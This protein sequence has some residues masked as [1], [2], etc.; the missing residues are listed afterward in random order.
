VIRP[1]A[2]L[3]NGDLEEAHPDTA[4]ARYRAAYPELFVAGAPA[5]DR[6]NLNAAIDL[7]ATYLRQGATGRAN[8]LLDSAAANFA[9]MP[10]L[11]DFGYRISDVHVHA[12]RGEKAKALAALRDAQA[13]GWH[14][15]LWRYH[16]DF[17]PNLASIRS[18]PEFK[19]I[20]GDIERDMAQQRARLA[21]SGRQE[22]C[23]AERQVRTTRTTLRFAQPTATAAAC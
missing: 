16:R 19:A 15:P 17:D 20:F 11:G 18:A 7:A 8:L 22:E 21:A 2:I 9:K 5:V 14:G 12:L 13:A 1:L 4:I 6:A 10:R 3:R 23:L